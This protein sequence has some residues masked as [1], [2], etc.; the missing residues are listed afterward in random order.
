[1]A[2]KLPTLRMTPLAWVYAGS[3]AVVLLLALL[4]GKSVFEDWRYG[5]HVRAAIVAYQRGGQN[6]ATAVVE[7]QAGLGLQPRAVGLAQVWVAVAASDESYRDQLDPALDALRVAAPND[8]FIPIAEGIELLRSLDERGVSAEERA[9][10]IAA[11]KEKFAAADRAGYPEAAVYLG[12][13][14]LLQGDLEASVASFETAAHAI[15][16]ARRPPTFGGLLALYCGYGAARIFHGEREQ[17]LLWARR[18]VSLSPRNELAMD[19]LARALQAWLILEPANDADALTAR[20]TEARAMVSRHEFAASVERQGLFRNRWGL[21]DE[22]AARVYNAIGFAELRGGRW[23]DAQ[24]D[25][26]RAIQ[27]ADHTDAGVP[28]AYYVNLGIACWQHVL[29]NRRSNQT[30]SPI[31]RDGA[32]AFDLALRRGTWD[33]P[34]RYALACNKAVLLTEAGREQQAET[35]FR[36]IYPDERPNL[37]AD[38]RAIREM[39]AHDGRFWRDWGVLLERIGRVRQPADRNARRCYQTAVDEGDPELTPTE[40]QQ[41]DAHKNEL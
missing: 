40:R 8:P 5:R 19:L 23:Q 37:S 21:F 33:L 4:W 15:Q 32:E 2:F 14:N 7:A 26:G 25:F 38:D 39:A 27:I 28:P 13:A 36:S 1:M 3:A 9:Q 29:A 18:A 16:E 31:A 10:R 24:E 22:R 30:S 12:V 6:L 11:A 41:I 17:G 20:I 35:A 34:T